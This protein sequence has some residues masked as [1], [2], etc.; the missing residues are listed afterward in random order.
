MTGIAILVFIIVIVTLASLAGLVAVRRFV[1]RK[2]LAQH[3]DVAG[4]VYAV[5][6]VIYGVI[7]A[8]VVVAAWDEYRD[9][10][11]AAANEAAA[12]LNLDRLSRGWPDQDRE[13]VR[14]ALIDYAE[15]VVD[16]EWP[17]MGAGD[18]ALAPVPDAVTNLWNTY[19]RIGQTPEGE[20][21]SYAASLGQLDAVDEARRNRYLLGAR[22][23]PQMMTVTLLAGGIVTVAFSYLF[24][25]ENGWIHGLITASLAILVGLLLFLEYQLETPFEG[26]DAIKP[27]A[28]QLALE[29][30]AADSSEGQ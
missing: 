2:Q 6:G 24:A 23:L 16:V 18:Y 17:A 5:I 7:L 11:G 21:A 15:L 3:T 10:N 4:Y 9:A 29:D 30:F 27:T 28:M 8:Q 26:I 25:V 13:Q 19:D 12:L 22:T 20:S 14:A 1:P